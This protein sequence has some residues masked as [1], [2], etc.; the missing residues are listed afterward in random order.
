MVV[1]SSGGPPNRTG[2]V[3][4]TLRGHEGSVYGVSFSPDGARILSCSADQT[5]R[6]WDAAT[7]E[8]L[9][10]MADHHARVRGN[11]AGFLPVWDR[12]L[13]TQVRDYEQDRKAWTARSGA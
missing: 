2:A 11:Y 5:V 8:Q 1:R 13:G 9:L 7:G 6:V 3:V 4:R 12:V 10:K